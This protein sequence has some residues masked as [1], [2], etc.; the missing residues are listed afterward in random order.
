MILALQGF[1]KVILDFKSELAPMLADTLRARG[2]DVKI[3]NLGDLYEDVVG[4]SESYNPLSL[5]A[6]LYLTPGRLRDV[7]EFLRGLNLQLLKEPKGDSANGDNKHFRDGSR[8]LLTFAQQL[9]VLID[10]ADASLGDVLSMLSDRKSLLN[11]AQWAAGKLAQEDGSLASMPIGAS[12]WAGEHEPSQLA[13]YIKYF[14]DL[15]SEIADMLESQDTKS[16]DSFIT[17][18]L[19]VLSNFNVSTRAHEKTSKTTFSFSEL[20]EGDKPTTVFLM[21]DAN[22]ADAQAPVLGMIQYCLLY[23]MKQHPNKKRVVYLIADETSNVPW[24]GLGSLM[25]WCRSYGLRILFIFQTFP[26]LE[27]AHGKNVVEIMQ[28]ECEVIL[29]LKGQKNPKTL[30]TI[31][32]L[33]SQKSIIAKSYSRNKE[34]GFGIHGS[35]LSETGR[36]LMTADE[37][38]RSK[39]SILIIRDNKPLQID[40]PSVASIHP[41]RTMVAGNPQHDYKPYLKPIKL[42]MGNRKGSIFLRP[43][44]WLKERGAA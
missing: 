8:K 24:S 7:S 18:A 39:K 35:N 42:R 40:V 2:E 25:T 15:A 13:N 31:E 10:G 32:E 44:R 36:P 1:D 5:L 11:H 3:I 17:D 19:E 41:W 14:R 38:R 27:E 30:K 26:A 20:K 43:F 37:I 34:Q 29:I 6:K 16:F 9:C 28:S 4:P 21:M 22:K 12:P 33:L 23:E